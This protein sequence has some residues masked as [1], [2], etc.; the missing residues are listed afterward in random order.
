MIILT[1]PLIILNFLAMLYYYKAT[2]AELRATSNQVF[3]T[4]TNVIEDI[5]EETDELFSAM[6]IHSGMHT[7]TETKDVTSLPHTSVLL[8]L[9]PISR[10][11]TYIKNASYI[12]SVDV[13]GYTPDYVLST[14]VSGNA[15][16]FSHKAWMNVSSD[17]LRFS[18]SSEDTFCICYNLVDNMKKTGLIIFNINP[19]KIN[20]ILGT[21]PDSSYNLALYNSNKELIYSSDEGMNFEPDF[22]AISED[23][24]LVQTNKSAKI[25]VSVGD[26]YLHMVAEYIRPVYTNFIFVVSIY[27]IAVLILSFLMAFFLSTYSYGMI[28]DI[29]LEINNAKINVLSDNSDNSINEIMYINQNITSMKN[30]NIE[31]EQELVKSFAELKKM[32]TQVLQMQLTPHFLFNALNTINVSLMLKNGVD[33]PESDSILVL[34]DLLSSSIDVKHYMVTIQQE[35]AYCEKYLKIQS[36]MSQNNFDFN[37]DTDDDI[38]DCIA[39]K[40][41]LQPLI[42]NAFRHGIKLLK[43]KERGILNISIKKENGLIRYRIENNGPTPDGETTNRINSMLATSKEINNDHVGLFNT[44][45]RI[46]L[47][48]GDE[49][50]CSINT[51]NGLTV[52]TITTPVVNDLTVSKDKQTK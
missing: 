30:K 7:F 50:G 18:I 12:E 22:D 11:E 23:G 1:I 32:H 8:M 10:A 24:N 49:Y 29:I 39:V 21:S 36:L 31:L 3:S 42:E 4:A 6:A 35:I 41:S 34:S 20:E 47:I 9:K 33:N 14:E 37:F 15:S 52:V 45:R 5:Y 28:K 27:S 40:F 48:F 17:D 16:D 51:E 44:N 43:D 19:D 13:Y 2:T 46:K 38:L 26:I 25:T